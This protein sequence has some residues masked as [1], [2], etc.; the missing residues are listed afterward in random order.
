MKRFIYGILMADKEIKART[1]E[2]L[3]Q[4]LSAAKTQES[5]P[6]STSNLFLILLKS[7][8]R[9]VKRRKSSSLRWEG[10]TTKIADKEGKV[11]VKL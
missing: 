2:K 9:K 1:L 4:V 7:F 5:S 3:L 8:P 6:H 10:P 11:V